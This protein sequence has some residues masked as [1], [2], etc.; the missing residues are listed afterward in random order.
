MAEYFEVEAGEPSAAIRRVRPSWRAI[1]G[2]HEVD[3]LDVD[4]QLV[5]R[6]GLEP[7]GVVG[8]E[9]VAPADRLGADE[10]VLLEP[11][12]RR[13]KK[14]DFLTIARVPDD[15]ARFA[16]IR[17]ERQVFRAQLFRTRNDDG[18]EPVERDHGVEPLR[19][20]RQQHDHAIALLDAEGAQ[21]ARPAPRRRGDLRKS[22][23]APRALRVER[24][25]AQ[26][27][28]AAQHVDDV[29]REVKFRRTFHAKSVMPR[30]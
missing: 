23:V 22:D 21:C 6:A 10:Q 13:A 15:G 26:P 2:A 24:H 29:A 28:F 27:I 7:R 9:L 3:Q 18:A 30:G 5:S 25:E 17:T 11:R 8:F 16:V 4:L 12:A 14:V 20:F 19:D 1:S